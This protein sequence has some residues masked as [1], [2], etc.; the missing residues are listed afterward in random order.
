MTALEL[1]SQ[2][3]LFWTLPFAG[4]LACIAILPLAAPRFWHSNRNK[5]IIAALFGLPVMF[6]IGLRAPHQL[7][8]VGGEYFS[9]ITLLTALFVVSGGIHLSGDLEATPLVNTLFLAA[10][11]VLANLVGTTGASMLLIR[12]LLSTNKERDNVAHIPVFFIFIVSNIG[13]SLLPIGDPPLFLGY[14]R[15]VP[16]FWTLRLFPVWAAA[17]GILLVI[18][19]VIDSAAHAKETRAALKLDASQVMPLKVTG[20]LNFAW[21]LGILSAAAF[22]Q[23][24]LREAAMI[25]LIAASRLTTHKDIHARNEYSHSPI[26]EVAVLFAGI[27]GAMIPCLLILKARGAGLGITQ[28]WQFFW[29]AG[30]LSSFLDNAPT[31][32]TFLSLAE[33]VTRAGA[34]P[35]A[36]VLKDGVVAGTLLKALSVGAVFMG[37]NSYIGN[38]PN[39]MV[40][41]ICDQRKFKCPHFLAYMLWAGTILIP[42]FI[43]L[44]FLFF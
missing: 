4:L 28:P 20:A 13:G 41:A 21:L 3:S 18:F 39:F 19:Y 1:G 6:F 37:A 7:L 12:A 26:I 33:G 43:L 15:G 23:S 40:K 22:L 36:M 8:S 35:G 29:G 10:G 24:P 14:L 34:L 9:F 27:F 31:Y 42:L 11:A 16:F 17:V 44:T 25:A 32:L 5:G 30:S 2:L 38:A